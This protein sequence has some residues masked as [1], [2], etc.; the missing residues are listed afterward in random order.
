V[1]SYD[2][3]VNEDGEACADDLLPPDEDTPE[4]IYIDKY[5][6]ENVEAEHLYNL[7]SDL[8]SPYE[9]QCFRLYLDG[10][11]YR[12]MVYRYPHL[13]SSYHLL[14]SATEKLI[15]NYDEVIKRL[16]D[17]GIA[18]PP[19]LIG[20]VPDGYAAAVEKHDRRVAR[21]RV[22]DDKRQRQHPVYSTDEERKAARKLAQIRFREKHR[23]LLNERC[24]QRRAAARAAKQAASAAVL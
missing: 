3:W 1:C 4:S 13:G 5:E 24:R 7:L 6:T 2:S 20:V 19:E 21:R 16:T 9:A 10:Y 18:V 12:E 14:T 23:E 11:T 22:P 15:R 8:L 17:D